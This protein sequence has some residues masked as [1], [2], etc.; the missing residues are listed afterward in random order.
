MTEQGYHVL[1]VEDEEAH[2]ELISMAFSRSGHAFH[3]T[4]VDNLEKAR[5]AL[6][7]QPPDMILV[8]W[9]LPDGKGLD[10]LKSSPAA[11]KCPFVVMTSH[12]SEQVAVDA[13]KA[14]ALDYIV[15]SPMAFEQ[16]PHAA[17]RAIREWTNIQERRLAEEKYRSIVEDAPV[18]IISTTLDGKI[19]SANPAIA[20]MYGY[21][22]GEEGTQV[23]GNIFQHVDDMEEHHRLLDVINEHGLVSDYQMRHVRSDGSAIWVSYTARA[24]KNEQGEVTS[25]EGFLTDITQRKLAEEQLKNYQDHL[26]R[27]V[28]ERTKELQESRQQFSDI[29]EFLPDATFVVNEEGV[30]VAWN[31]AMEE[32]TRV[33]KDRI[34]GKGNHE[35]GIHL[36]GV[37]KPVLIDLILAGKAH[38]LRRDS[39]GAVAF[40]VETFLERLRGGKGAFVSIKASPLLDKQ[41]RIIGAIE[42]VRDIT[43]RKQA[44]MALKEQL[45]FVQALIDAIPTPIY[46]R[47]ADGYFK[48]SNHAFEVMVGL[49]R[50]EIVGKP[51]ASIFKADLVEHLQQLEQPLLDGQDQLV[52]ETEVLS[53][54][55]PFEAVMVHKAAHKDLDGRVLGIVS[56]ITDITQR[57]HM[58]GELIQAKELAEAA[59]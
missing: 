9:M 25:L 19:L 4:H 43:I 6:A 41:G 16:M 39:E 17:R 48:L 50:E 22:S 11:E 44:E 33:S 57:K 52:F 46:Y 15:K 47:D 36:Y 31:Q 18:G 37:R 26:E 34:L 3:L 51:V 59:S 7:E 20:Q 14:G 38:A 58:E 32:L 53:K 55:L 27:E 30:V 23:L 12:G 54:S 40:R 2:A 1:L 49:S 28:L 35:Y 5:Q 24:V 21:T 42:S 13:L 45:T 10:L 56:V 29:I 8:D